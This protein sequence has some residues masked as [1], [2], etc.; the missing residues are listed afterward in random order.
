MNS[1]D[2]MMCSLAIEHNALAPVLPPHLGISR[3]TLPAI[4]KKKAAH[5]APVSQSGNAMKIGQ[6]HTFALDKA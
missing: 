3:E 2:E 5:Y 1:P 4:P 6:F